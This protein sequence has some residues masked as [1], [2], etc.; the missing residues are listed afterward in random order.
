[1]RYLPGWHLIPDFLELVARAGPPRPP[2]QRRA[3]WRSSTHSE[4]LDGETELALDEL[5]LRA[6]EISA[7]ANERGILAEARDGDSEEAY[8]PYLALELAEDYLAGDLS[9]Q[10][11]YVRDHASE[12]LDNEEFMKALG[13]LL[14]EN[15]P[16]HRSGIALLELAESRLLEQALTVLGDRSQFAALA[17]QTVLG[18][19]PGPVRA[20]SWLALATS[21]DQPTVAA[22]LFYEAVA[23]VLSAQTET[24]ADQLRSARRVHNTTVQSL[25]P[26]LLQLTAIH[27]E[28]AVLAPVLSEPSPDLQ[29]VGG[30]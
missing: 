21:T 14:D 11:Q 17:G 16:S 13:Q 9:M 4:L 3:P 8:R 29:D 6:G 7:T 19:D 10:T 23:S 18:S 30:A 2:I 15:N 28:M 26:T 22:A 12:L 1:M 24:G 27:P 5:D 20:L 25:V